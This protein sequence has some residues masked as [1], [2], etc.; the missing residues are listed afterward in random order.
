MNSMAL[1]FV[2]EVD[3]MDR[4][5]SKRDPS[6]ASCEKFPRCP[7]VDPMKLLMVFMQLVDDGSF[8]KR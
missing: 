2:L 1:T 6:R 8:F 4:E 3:E 5:P 7:A